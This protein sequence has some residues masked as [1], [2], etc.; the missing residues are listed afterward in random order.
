MAEQTAR[1]RELWGW[2][3]YDVANQA[4]TTI[5]ISFV[6]SAFFV[7]YIVPADSEWRDAY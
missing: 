1:K 7:N 3:M 2:A 4:Y 6:Y 5:V